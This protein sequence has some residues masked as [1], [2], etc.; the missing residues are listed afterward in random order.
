MGCHIT[1]P[2]DCK[3]YQRRVCGRRRLS[4]IFFNNILSNTTMCTVWKRPPT[5][6]DILLKEYWGTG[7][8]GGGG[9]C[10]KKPQLQLSEV[11]HQETGDICIFLLFPNN[12]NHRGDNIK[13]V[14]GGDSTVRLWRGRGKTAPRNP[15]PTLVWT[16]LSLY[17]SGAS[18]YHQQFH[19]QGFDGKIKWLKERFGGSHCWDIFPIWLHT[20]ENFLGLELHYVYPFHTSISG[21]T[22]DFEHCVRVDPQCEKVTIK[23]AV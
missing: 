12:R 21:R 16:V 3:L 4:W 10:I 23:M 7:A 15:T 8:G 6:I 11:I 13:T 5:I 14:L 19:V 1:P 18:T 22:W 17:R 2:H 9:G 20:H